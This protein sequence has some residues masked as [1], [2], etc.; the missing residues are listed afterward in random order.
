VETKYIIMAPLAYNY[1]EK[2]IIESERQKKR[3][4]LKKGHHHLHLH[5]P[6]QSLTRIETM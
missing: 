5:L 6:L 4:S 2:N 1:K 3:N